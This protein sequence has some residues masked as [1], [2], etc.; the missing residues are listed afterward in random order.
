[1]LQE[2][3]D[4][5]RSDQSDDEH[6]S[7]TSSSAGFHL[8]QPVKVIKDP[9]T[10]TFQLH[11][12][13]QG[14]TVTLLGDSASTHSFLNDKFVEQLSKVTTQKNVFRVEVYDGAQLQSDQG[15]MNCP[16]S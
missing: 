16:W 9:S 10:L 12:I 8:I 7:T 6:E 14:R 15:T 3:T 5:F 13:V 11:G 1:V 2:V 4:L